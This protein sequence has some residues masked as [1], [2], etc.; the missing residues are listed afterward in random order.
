M[1]TILRIYTIV[2]GVLVA[3]MSSLIV[4]AYGGFRIPGLWSPWPFTKWSVGADVA[5]VLLG[6]AAV[7][8]PWRIARF[9]RTRK[10][11]PV[12]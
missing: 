1:M 7:A 9:V 12:R 3:V 10:G 11:G 6:F 5:K 4:L 2:A 8:V